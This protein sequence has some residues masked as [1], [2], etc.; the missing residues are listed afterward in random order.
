MVTKN[1]HHAVVHILIIL[2]PYF[3]ASFKIIFGC[4]GKRIMTV[5]PYLQKFSKI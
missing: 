2:V 1:I 4:E 5:G 3:P